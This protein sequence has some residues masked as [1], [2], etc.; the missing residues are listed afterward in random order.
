MKKI[1]DIGGIFFRSNDPE[2]DPFELWEPA[3]S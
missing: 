1:L 3:K 2:G